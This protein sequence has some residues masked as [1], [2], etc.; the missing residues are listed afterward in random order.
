MTRVIVGVLALW[1]VGGTT[2]AD[3]MLSNLHSSHR[4]PGSFWITFKKPSELGKISVGELQ[5]V[6]VLP[7]VLPNSE[8]NLRLLATAWTRQIGAELTGVSWDADHPAFSVRNATDEAI[9]KQ[10]AKDPRIESIGANIMQ[11]PV[12]SQGRPPVTR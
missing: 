2:L 11:L 8:T 3:A 6:T 10:L 9:T 7:G 5:A 4:S 1:V 12:E